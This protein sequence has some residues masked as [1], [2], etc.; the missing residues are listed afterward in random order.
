MKV[1]GVLATVVCIVLSTGMLAA[2]ENAS[3][4]VFAKQGEEALRQ[5]DYKKAAKSWEKAVNLDS[6]NADYRASLGR[7]YEREAEVS[8]FP[9]VLTGKARQQFVR[10][11]ELQPDHARAIQDLIELAQQPVGLCEGDL[12]EAS[13][14]IDRLAQVDPDAAKRQR[15]Y[16]EDA[17]RESQR[18]GQRALCGP[19][20]LSRLVTDHVLP[21]RVLSASAGKANTAASTAVMADK[22]ASD[23]DAVWVAGSTK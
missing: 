14:L 3:A 15:E 21:Y 13:L 23:K 17:K 6:T 20:K 22:G 1:H 12:K 16:W 7:A 11:I 4:E 10:A 18:P 5:G 2:E 8:S 9:L 19:V